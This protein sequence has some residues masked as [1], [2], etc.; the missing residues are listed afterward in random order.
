MALPRRLTRFL[1]LFTASAREW[2]NDK[3][4]RLG[5]ALSYYTIFSLAPVLLLVIAVAGMA[6]GAQAA[7]GKVVDQLSGL[8]GADAAK[9]V[10]TMLEKSNHHGGGIV[11]TIIGFV[12]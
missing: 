7:Q 10:Q 1:R 9:A 8:L 6:L 3:A 12:T 4:P 2:S 11:A 5:A